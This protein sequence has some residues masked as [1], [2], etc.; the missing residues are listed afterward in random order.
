M[1][2]RMPVTL[3]GDMAATLTVREEF[4][5]IATDRQ[6]SVVASFPALPEEVRR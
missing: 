5:E 4:T 6:Q 3:D 2:I 1:E